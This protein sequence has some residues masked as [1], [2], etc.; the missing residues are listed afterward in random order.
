MDWDLDD[1]AFEQWTPAPERE[2]VPEGKH[3]FKIERA[4]ED[5][6]H[7][8]LAMSH[9]DKR[10]AWVWP[11]LPKG[12]DWGKRLGSELRQALGMTREEWH[13]HA[14][15][16]MVGRRVVADV[17]HRVVDGRT[18]VNVGKFHPAQEPTPARPAAN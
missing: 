8:G 12:R 5:A 16:D 11:K 15:D 10:Y 6:E 13:R 14:I 7:L 9:S 1:E 3:E 18:F 2:L 4:S 17:Y